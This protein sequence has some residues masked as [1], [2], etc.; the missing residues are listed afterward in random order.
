MYKVKVK[1]C[2]GFAKR[3]DRDNKHLAVEG[4]EWD[5]HVQNKIFGNSTSMFGSLSGL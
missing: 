5:K 1:H 3:V 4:K 2:N